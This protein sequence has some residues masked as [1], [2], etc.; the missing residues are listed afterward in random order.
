MPKIS[1]VSIYEYINEENEI[2]YLYTIREDD[3]DINYKYRLLKHDEND[4]IFIEEINNPLNELKK[5]TLKKLNDEKYREA[6]SAYMEIIHPDE[7]I[8]MTL[9]N[10]K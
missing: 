2:G 4:N 10:I 6:I 3:N 8:K 1:F 7:Q 5:L 9:T